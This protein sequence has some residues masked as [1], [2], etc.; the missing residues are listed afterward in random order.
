MLNKEEAMSAV[1]LTHPLVRD[2]YVKKAASRSARRFVDVLVIELLDRGPDREHV[3]FDSYL[4]DL[5]L[6]LQ[7]LKEQA[8][9]QA[10][11]IDRIDICTH[12]SRGVA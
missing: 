3:G 7:V 12:N 8:E 1:V 9:Q 5:V 10:G 11:A 6:D 2:A 4:C